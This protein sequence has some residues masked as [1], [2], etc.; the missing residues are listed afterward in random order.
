MLVLI[1]PAGV[2]WFQAR[3]YSAELLVPQQHMSED[4]SRHK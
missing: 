1:T 2:S 4:G 3:I